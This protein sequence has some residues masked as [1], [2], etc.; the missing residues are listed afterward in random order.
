VDR[1]LSTGCIPIDN[2]LG[3]G[4]DIGSITQIYGPPA[5]GKTNISLCATTETVLNN[6]NVVYIDTEG[7]SINRFHQLS[8]NKGDPYQLGERLIISEVH[9]FQ[10]QA[11]AIKNVEKLAPN[12]ELIILD[13]ATGFYRLEQ[14]EKNDGS[15]LRAL[16]RQMIM[17]L[18]LARRFDL[19]VIITN[20][21]YSNPE[22]NQIKP[23]GGHIL[24][25][26]NGTVLRLDRFKRGN[27]RVTIEKH[28]SRPAG[29]S[30]RFVIEETGLVGTDEI[31]FLN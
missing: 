16:A 18:S 11:D 12:T 24:P 25:H 20:Q 13:S 21:I 27:R 10:E 30:A 22:T 1:K 15:T 2:L 17:L 6:K 23:L 3:G 14:A 9:S 19:A 26:W 4:V 7:V 29:E 5:S 31:Q 8:R 28:R